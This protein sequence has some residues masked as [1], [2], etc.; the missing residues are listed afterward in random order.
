M[1]T[2]NSEGSIAIWNLDEQMLLGQR[3]YAHTGPITALYFVKGS[4]YMISAGV[5][6]R[7]IKWAVEEEQSL[8]T[9]NTELSGHSAPVTALAIFGENAMV[10]ASADGYVRSYNIVRDDIMKSLG[11]AREVKK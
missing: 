10:S 3:P 6:N 9:I 5:D 8:P 1:V 4:P 7:M 11:K 2:G